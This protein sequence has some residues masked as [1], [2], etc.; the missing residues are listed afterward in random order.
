MR[1]I[2][3]KMIQKFRKPL[4]RPKSMDIET[5]KPKDKQENHRW[6]R[7]TSVEVHLPKSIIETT[8]SN[9]PFWFFERFTQGLQLQW[10]SY[11]NASTILRITCAW[12]IKHPK[13]TTKHKFDPKPYFIT[14]SACNWFQ[15]PQLMEDNIG[16]N[17]ASKVAMWCTWDGIQL[18]ELQEVSPAD[19]LQ[20]S[21]WMRFI[22]S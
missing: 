12:F 4:K 6:N 13:H 10:T 5:M 2:I 15:Y 19:E 1:R 8:L 16:L 9:K 17:M 22:S 11:S 20:F 3:L 18:S 21:C 14:T 7:S